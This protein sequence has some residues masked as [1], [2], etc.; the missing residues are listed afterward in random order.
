MTDDTLRITHNPAANR[1]Q[2]ELAGA[3]A[4]LE[5]RIAGNTVTIFHTLVPP[6]HRGQGVA[7][8]LAR[9]ALDWARTQS[10]RVVPQCSYI[11]AFMRRNREY[12]DLLAD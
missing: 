8:E 9:T 4:M 10:L 5:Y 11:A 6:E 1:F 7:A 2:A 3:T 12:G